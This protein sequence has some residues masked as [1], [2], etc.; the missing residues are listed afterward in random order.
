MS[1]TFTRETAMEAKAKHEDTPPPPDA[2]KDEDD[3]RGEA[4]APSGSKPGGCESCEDG[5]WMATAPPPPKPTAPAPWLQ[6]PLTQPV[7]SSTPPVA[8]KDRPLPA[9]ELGPETSTKPHQDPANAG[10]VG[11]RFDAGKPPMHLLPWDAL[12]V[13]A[14]VFGAGAAK[15]APR[16]WE[17]GMDAEIPLACEMRHISK[18]AQGEAN[19]GETGL[20]HAAH[21]ACNALMRLAYLVRADEDA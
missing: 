21:A 19:D 13:V 10:K 9:K 8:S 5:G 7:V 15:Y 20:P 14:Q 3:C 4:C 17:L 12:E 2:W 1:D 18:E 16:N 11:L 6:P